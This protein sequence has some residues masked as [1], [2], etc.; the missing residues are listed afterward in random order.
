MIIKSSSDAQVHWYGMETA[1]LVVLLH[2]YMGRLPWIDTFARRLAEEGYW[3]AV[4]DFFAGRT[5]TSHDDAV[6]LMNERMDDVP[7]AMRVIQ[8]VIGEGRALGSRTV[9]VIGFSMG[10]RLGFAYAADHPGVDALIGYYGRPYDPVAHVRAPVRFQLGYDDVEDGACDAYTVQR[11]MAEQGFEDVEI[12][13][14]ESARHG[15]QNV[16]NTEKYD[17]EAA[18]RAF[19]RTLRFLDERLRQPR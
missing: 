11:E 1:P 12:V 18:E 6:V 8:E 7:N 13:V 17:A 14:E 4:P 3:V 15:F 5:T 2:D 9:G 16:Q 10:V 19:A